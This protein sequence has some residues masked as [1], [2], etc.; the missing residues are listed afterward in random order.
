MKVKNSAQLLSFCE[1][2]SPHDF[3]LCS[4]KPLKPKN[5]VLKSHWE[6][7]TLSGLF[8]TNTV[9]FGKNVSGTVS[10]VSANSRALVF[11]FTNLMSVDGYS[12]YEGSPG[13]TKCSLSINFINQQPKK[14]V[15]QKRNISFHYI[16]QN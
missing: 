6:L 10:E 16:N 4:S 7:I 13:L 9:K 15:N 3:S 5:M 11:C 8:T 2:M 12:M 1:K 14:N